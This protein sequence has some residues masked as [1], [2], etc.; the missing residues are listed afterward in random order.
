MDRE[1]IQQMQSQ[2]DSMAQKLD[3]CTEF[4]F[5]SDLQKPL[6]Y[7][8]WRNFLTAITR[9][10]E[11]CERAKFS[12]G[13]HFVAINKMITLGKGGQR[14]IEDFMLTRYACY[15]IAQNGD[16]S[17]EPIAFSQCYFAVQIRK[18]EQ[19]EER[20]RLQARLEARDRLR[21]S[22]KTLSRNIYERDVD[23]A[24]F[25]CIR[26]K[27]DAALFGGYAPPR[28]ES[29]L[30]NNPEQTVGGF[31]ANP[32][33]CSKESGYGNDKPQCAAGRLAW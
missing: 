14:E 28:D 31:S 27:G 1:L 15:L 13:D 4:W 23:S 29:S 22:E 32:D 8:E 26:S 20:M 17:K 9:A 30:W 33:H 3:D 5:A 18:Q 11:S 25:G 24:G 10:I 19:I 12:S 16:S 21:E 2:F 7:S 6:G